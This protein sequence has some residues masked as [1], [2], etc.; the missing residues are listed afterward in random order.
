V[1][2]TDIG[3]IVAAV[4][5]AGKLAKKPTGLLAQKSPF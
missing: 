4:Q 2:E 1:L 3:D 5:E